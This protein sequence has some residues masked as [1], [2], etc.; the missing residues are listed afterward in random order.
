MEKE[1]EKPH[2][3]SDFDTNNDPN[4]KKEID[5]DKFLETIKIASELLSKWHSLTKPLMGEL[6]EV[7]QELFEHQY[8]GIKPYRQIW[9]INWVKESMSLHAS[10]LAHRLIYFFEQVEKDENY[11][12]GFDDY[13]R[14]LDLYVNPYVAKR[15]FFNG[16]RSA[17]SPEQLEI[18]DTVYEESYQGDLI[19]FAEL[20]KR[21]EEYEKAVLSPTLNFYEEEYHALSPD[22]KIHYNLIVDFAYS[23]Y[24]DDCKELDYYLIKKNMVEFPGVS[25]HQFLLD[26]SYRRLNQSKTSETDSMKVN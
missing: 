7:H 12:E 2:V 6:E 1:D 17:L 23:E 21:K 20:N 5:W 10:Q 19:G 26:E 14:D 4:A 13:Q 11:K 22:Q 8:P 24:F 3:N 15:Y 16:D 9:H 18:I 25:Y